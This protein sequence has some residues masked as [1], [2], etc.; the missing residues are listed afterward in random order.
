MSLNEM[1]GRKHS[2]T[3]DG[4]SS[5]GIVERNIA[6]QEDPSYITYR[7]TEI[8]PENPRNINAI[9]ANPTELAQ[10]RGYASSKYDTLFLPPAH[11]PAGGSS[12]TGEEF[13]QKII[14]GRPMTTQ[15]DA[16]LHD[17]L[18]SYEYR[19]QGVRSVET[20]LTDENLGRLADFV[21]DTSVPG[22]DPQLTQ[23]F[24]SGVRRNPEMFRLRA[25]EALRR[26]A[27]DPNG[28]NGLARL[29]GGLERADRLKDYSAYKKLDAAVNRFVEK[30]EKFAIPRSAVEEAVAAWRGK[31]PVAALNVLDRNMKGGLPYLRA[32]TAFMDLF[33]ISLRASF[34]ISN[35]KTP[36]MRLR[37]IDKNLVTTLGTLA[38]LLS[39]D[40][41]FR[42]AIADDLAKMAS[43][44][45]IS[46]RSADTIPAETSKEDGRFREKYDSP[47]GIGNHWR[48][49]YTTLANDPRYAHAGDT[50][51]V[52]LAAVEAERS[53]F[54]DE[55]TND[56]R[57]SLN[58]P[59]GPT[60][61]ALIV[62]FL[63]W[64]FRGR[65]NREVSR[66]P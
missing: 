1:A 20:H 34:D 30:Y 27:M 29:A 61:S 37:E 53:R 19:E 18:V 31:G 45:K 65:L 35:I 6:A 17:I 32:H 11:P 5:Y 36:A 9:A 66:R 56:Y 57:N 49:R 44:V 10:F 26:R 28:Y 43:G 62:E 40:P 46:P 2:T 33:K 22:A 50:D 4:E 7:G 39:N 41:E 51:P 47:D 42:H 14:E 59:D 13:V 25:I 55:S 24:V 64:L 52:W 21:G 38:P 48:A 58:R 16:L 12:A 15:E 23:F 60:R 63:V 54:I 3:R 8:K